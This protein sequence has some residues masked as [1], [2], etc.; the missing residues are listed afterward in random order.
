MGIPANLVHSLDYAFFL[1]AMILT[2]IWLLKGRP[3]A[4]TLAPV[5][6]VFVI[7]TGVPILPTPVLQ[8]ARRLP[9]AWGAA[10]PI[11]TLTVIFLCLLA[12]LLGSMHAC[13]SGG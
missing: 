5:F 1:P 13:E 8:A 4:F 11:G 7:L 10:L 9:A 2:G 3:L 12:W 6:A